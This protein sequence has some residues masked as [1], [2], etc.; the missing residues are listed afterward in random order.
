MSL[1]KAT[2][3]AFH[4]RLREAARA[5]DRS[6]PDAGDA[7]WL[8]AYLAAAHGDFAVAE[9]LARR[10]LHET[11]RE[12]ILVA[13]AAVTLA[14]VLRQTGRHAAAR[15]VEATALRRA[16]RAE[17]R[18]HLLIGLAADGVGLGDLAAV[19]AA[20]RRVPSSA[21]HWRVRVRLRWVRCEREL[22]AGRPSAAVGHARAAAVIAERE[23]AVRHAAKSHLF[24]GAAL[25]DA[26]R[27]RPH[28]ARLDREA[29]R[30]LRRAS[31][32]ATRAGARPVADVAAELLARRALQARG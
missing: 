6:G 16:R 13:R 12:P 24:L 27:R 9:T 1:E 31:A 30:S 14:S 10:V 8:R 17:D 23:K 3:L 2:D 4:G 28:D 11:Q 25:L 15:D 32:L 18:A 5:L 7:T 26:A 19:D 21:R 29:R 22:L 20:L